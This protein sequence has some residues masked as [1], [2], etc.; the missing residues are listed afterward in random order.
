MFNID[1]IKL[2]E[3]N[4]SVGHT[5]TEDHACYGRITVDSFSEVFESP[6]CFWRKEQ[7]EEQWRAA[8]ARLMPC[9]S[10]RTALLTA[11]YDPPTANFLTWWPVYREGTRVFV[12]NQL[13]FLDQLAVPFDIANISTIV[14]PRQT[15]DP[16]GRNISEWSCDLFD[17][18]EFLRAER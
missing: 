14:Q 9:K 16:D 10:A 17:L 12:Q 15:S 4:N 2:D 6:L 5:S 13:L 1:F 18:N 11:M 8:I 7:Y 3:S